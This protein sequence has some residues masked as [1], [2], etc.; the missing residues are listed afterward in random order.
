MD[1]RVKVAPSRISFDILHRN[2][3]IRSV[4]SVHRMKRQGYS[5][6]FRP[7]NSL[8][9]ASR[10]RGRRMARLKNGRAHPALWHIIY[11]RAILYR[12]QRKR[13]I[14]TLHRSLCGD[15]LRGT[16]VIAASSF[17]KEQHSTRLRSLIIVFYRFAHD[18]RCNV[19]ITGTVS[20]RIS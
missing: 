7:G 8:R 4:A 3:A 6:I 16:T 19:F 5:G 9:R 12:R 10:L 2:L 18:D 15:R 1:S 20:W 13:K 14:A 11:S 17:K